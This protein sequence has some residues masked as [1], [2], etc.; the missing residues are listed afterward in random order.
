MMEKGEGNQ[1][2]GQ[3]IDEININIDELIYLMM[4]I[5]ILNQVIKLIYYYR[6]LHHQLLIRQ[7]ILLSN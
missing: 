2:K 3:R 5:M 1:Y 7:K 4:M 6:K